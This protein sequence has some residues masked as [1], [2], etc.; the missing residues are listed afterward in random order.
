M[1]ILDTFLIIALHVLC[2][3]AGVKLANYYNRL[4]RQEVKDA[5]ER[6]FVRL[7]ARSDADDPCKPY[8]SRLK[9]FEP[10][11]DYDGDPPSLFTTEMMDELKQNGKIK[12]K[13]RK[14]DLTDSDRLSAG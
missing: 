4:T 5:L 7:Q 9:K 10:T 11:G 6:Q 14:S 13:F 2:F 12:T 1:E 8:V 3:I